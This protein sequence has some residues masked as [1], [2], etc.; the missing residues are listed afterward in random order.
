MPIKTVA[1]LPRINRLEHVVIPPM[2]SITLPKPQNA[3]AVSG[4]R[5]V[6]VK[7]EYSRYGNVSRIGFRKRKRIKKRALYSRFL[8][9]PFLPITAG[10]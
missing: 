6:F 10:G 3:K 2:I 8:V 5:I 4:E 7:K 9:L 1:S